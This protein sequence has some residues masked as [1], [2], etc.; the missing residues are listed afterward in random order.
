M[1]EIIFNKNISEFWTPE[2]CFIQE[3][4]NDPSHPNSSL[5]VARVPPGVTT[6][7]HRLNGTE[8]TY[9]IKRGDGVLEIDGE[10]S[11]LKLGDAIIIPAGAS[12]KISNIGDEDLEF[13]CL[14]TPR[15]LPECY[16]DLED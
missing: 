10:K 2:R 3:I 9:I 12:Q 8:E 16:E 1:P 15:F 13:F 7:L 5:A 4:L 11:E 6:Q 14:C